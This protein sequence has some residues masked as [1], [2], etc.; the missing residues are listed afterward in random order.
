MATKG[1]DF[2]ECYK[3][4]IES[5]ID[6]VKVNFINL[7]SLKKNKKAI[8]RYQDLADFENLD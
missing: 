6:E 1:I 2:Q 4:R 7:E 5:N 3:K 8:G